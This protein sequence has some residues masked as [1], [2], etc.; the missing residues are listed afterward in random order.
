MSAA[1]AKTTKLETAV[2]ARDPWISTREAGK[3]LDI[4]QRRVQE[5]AQS[6]ALRSA[7]QRDPAS[8]QMMVVVDAEDVE[9]LRQERKNPVTLPAIPRDPSALVRRVP[10]APVVQTAIPATIFYNL[11]E[12]AAYTG[13]PESFL[14]E[15]ILAG[16]LR[17]LYVGIRAGG[18]WRVKRTDLDAIQGKLQKG[19]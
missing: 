19:S 10:A 14:L 7:Q 16:E 2:A 1:A 6:G 3:R 8:R 5:L 15:A 17:A 9:R 11:A 18:R 13:L 12:A 4:S